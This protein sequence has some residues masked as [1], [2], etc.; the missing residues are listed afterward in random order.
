[1]LI[2]VVLLLAGCGSNT[3]E[4]IDE[5]LTTMKAHAESAG[6]DT[7]QYLTDI[8]EF[9]DYLEGIENADFKE[10]VEKQLEANEMRVEALQKEDSDLIK[11]S[12]YLQLE[13]LFLYNELKESQ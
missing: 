11:E 5:H 13:A 12:A 3:A 4:M 7:E 6:A 1:M 2:V 9:N 8:Q 10:Y